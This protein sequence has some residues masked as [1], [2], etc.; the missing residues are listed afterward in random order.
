MIDNPQARHAFSLAR[1]NALPSSIMD[2]RFDRSSK[3]QGQCLCTQVDTESLAH[4]LLHCSWY[5]DLRQDI[6]NSLLVNLQGRS[7][8]GTIQTLLST[9]NKWTINQLAKFFQLSI[10]RREAIVT[11][12]KEPR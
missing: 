9:T 8:S 4:V 5:N 10:E 12:T 6:L 3:A 7:D 11:D 1:C 2:Y